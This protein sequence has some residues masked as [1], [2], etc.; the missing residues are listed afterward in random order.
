MPPL[1]ID[2]WLRLGLGV[3]IVFESEDGDVSS[4]V[5]CV[6]GPERGDPILR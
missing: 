5:F 6:H 2:C 4:G 3:S 1:R